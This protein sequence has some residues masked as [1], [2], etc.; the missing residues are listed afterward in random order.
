M[1][2]TDRYSHLVMTT[3]RQINMCYLFLFQHRKVEL[4][5]EGYD[6]QN[7]E[8]SDKLYFYSRRD[9]NYVPMTIA[10]VADINTG[11]LQF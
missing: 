11:K 9:S 5:K 1:L 6:F 7:F 8:E 3:E 10:M 4:V 2:T